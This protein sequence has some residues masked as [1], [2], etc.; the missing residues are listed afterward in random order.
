MMKHNLSM[1]APGVGWK[2]L[3]V[4]LLATAAIGIALGVGLG[5]GLGEWSLA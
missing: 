2:M 5:V 3:L 1:V 4:V